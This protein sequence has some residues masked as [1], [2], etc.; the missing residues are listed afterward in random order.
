MNPGDRI[1]DFFIVSPIADG[2]MGRVFL[3]RNELS[4]LPIAIKILPERFLDD[5]KRSQYLQREVMIAQRLRHPNVIDIYD[6]VTHKG[7]GYLLME[8]VDGG[9]LRQH[10]KSL[11]LSLYDVLNLVQ[12]ICEGLHYIHNHRLEDGRFHSII[13]R[14]IKP[15]NILLTQKGH[16]KVADFGLSYSDDSWSLRRPRSRSGTPH[17]MS[18]EQIRGRPLDIRTDIF[19]LGLVMYELLAGQLPYKTNDKAMYMKS[20]ISKGVKPAPPS[21]INKKI[22]RQ[23]DDI[24]MRALEKNPA[25]RYQTVTELLLDLKR[26]PSVLKRLSF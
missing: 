10:T 18:P 17:Y 22:P 2:G 4:G 23:L 7:I 15:E 8:Y 20:M 13:H 14:D 26:L 25:D 12:K 1:G 21:Y 16:P 19:S 5:R 9:N 11:Q 6:L 24:T 3:A